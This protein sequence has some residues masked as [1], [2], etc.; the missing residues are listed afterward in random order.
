LHF[1]A[2]GGG[3]ALA[4]CLAVMVS[5]SAAGGGD[6]GGGVPMLSAAGGA[7]VGSF[8]GSRLSL[9]AVRVSDCQ[10]Q[11]AAVMVSRSA[12]SPGCHGVG[13]RRRG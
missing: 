4:R 2:N 11:G 12:S 5:R 7:G 13:S 10:Q 3:G 6:L 9:D 8:T 1:I